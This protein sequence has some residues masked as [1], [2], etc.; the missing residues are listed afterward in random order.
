M[1]EQKNVEKEWWAEAINTAAY[2]TNDILNSLRPYST[3]M[4]ISF[5]ATPDL[6]HLP[7]IWIYWVCAYRK[8]KRFKLDA[9]AYPCLFLG[10]AD[11]SKAYRVI[12]R[13]TKRVEISR[14][15][16]LIERN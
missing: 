5:K 4:E 16:Q 3:P 6:S 7:C 12:N 2:I 11:H 13:L 8:S 1:M 15:T 10:Y 9:N 14:S